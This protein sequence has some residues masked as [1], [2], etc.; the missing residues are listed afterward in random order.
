M[1]EPK[2]KF[3]R[4]EVSSWTPDELADEIERLQLCLAE[5][6]RARRAAE[7][8]A[9]EIGEH[10]HSACCYLDRA[11]PVFGY[12]DNGTRIRAVTDEVLRLREYAGEQWNAAIEAAKGTIHAHLRH[13]VPADVVPLVDACIERLRL[14]RREQ[15]SMG[16]V[17]DSDRL[18]WLERKAW[19]PQPW[20]SIALALFPFT[21]NGGKYMSLANV[22]EYNEEGLDDFAE[23]GTLREA[24]DAAMKLPSQDLAQEPKS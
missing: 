24:I 6:Q 1:S 2:C 13:V 15:S 23:G 12:P 7:E 14:L 8:N 18:D 10:F 11:I 20:G 21:R 22:D 17:S 16:S 19:D 4:E 5:E 9:A 3:I